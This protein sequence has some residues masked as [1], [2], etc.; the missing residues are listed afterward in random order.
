MALRESN[1][2]KITIIF[3]KYLSD[4]YYSPYQEITLCPTWEMLMIED[5]AVIRKLDS[6]Q[7]LRRTNLKGVI[8]K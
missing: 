7:T 2:Q 6:I 8:D 4:T 3:F 1:K 5:I